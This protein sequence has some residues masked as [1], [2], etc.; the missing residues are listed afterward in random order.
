MTWLPPAGRR[1]DQRAHLVLA[2][3]ERL[4]QQEVVAGVQQRDGGRHVKAVHGAVD[5]GVG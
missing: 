3:R 2:G 4:L 5:R 1:L